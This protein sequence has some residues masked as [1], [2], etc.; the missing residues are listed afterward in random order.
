MFSHWFDKR[1]CPACGHKMFTDGNNFYCGKCGFEI[2]AKNKQ[3]KTKKPWG[4]RTA[5]DREYRRN[6]MERDE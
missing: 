1:K 4:Y 6:D 2:E 5:Y 3:H